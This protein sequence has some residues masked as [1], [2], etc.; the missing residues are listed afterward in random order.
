MVR[1]AALIA[2][3]WALAGGATAAP[4][5]KILIC[6]TPHVVALR[7]RDAVTIPKGAGFTNGYRDDSGDELKP[8]FNI[9]TTQDVV[10][11]PK[12]KCVVAPAVLDVN[13]EG[14][15]LTTKYPNLPSQLNIPGLDVKTRVIEDFR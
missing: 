9:H 6:R 8:F 15:A 7:D 10:L 12:P 3:A 1:A 14:F 4:T 5:G 13:P 11:P 2:A